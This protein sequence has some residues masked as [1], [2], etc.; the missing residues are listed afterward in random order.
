VGEMRASLSGH[1]RSTVARM[2]AS[3]CS[4]P[5][6]LAAEFLDRTGTFMVRESRPEL[7]CSNR[8]KSQLSPDLVGDRVY[9]HDGA[10]TRTSLLKMLGKESYSVSTRRVVLYR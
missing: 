5:I 3:Y 7:A 4:G 9:G 10:Y 2:D 6:W 1:V 8:F